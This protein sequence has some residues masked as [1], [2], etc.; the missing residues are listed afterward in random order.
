MTSHRNRE[1][2]V[3]GCLGVH[4][5]RKDDDSIHL[6]QKGLVERIVGAL[7]LNNFDSAAVETPC[8]GFLQT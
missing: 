2:S 1:D 8:T 4:I 3:A 6:T 7:N 5:D